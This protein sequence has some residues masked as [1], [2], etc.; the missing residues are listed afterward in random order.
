MPKF[1]AWLVPSLLISAAGCPDVS[2]DPGEGVDDTATAGPVVEFDPANKVLPFPNNLVLDPTTGKVNLPKQ[3]NE[4]A[5]STSTRENVLN[6]LDGF[7]TYE[8][9]MSVTFTE[10]V[11]EATLTDRVVLYKRA[12][13]MTAA[14]TTA[15]PVLLRKGTTIRYADQ[16]ML[17]TT[18]MCS[19]PKTIDSVTIIP[20]VP[21]DQKSTYTVAVLKGV[22]TATGA[23]YGSTFTWSLIRQAENPVTLDAQGNVVSDRTPLLPSDPAQY[24]QLKGIDLLWK[25]HA[26]AL[27]FLSAKHAREDVLI[28]WEFN[29]QTVTDPLDPTVAGSLAAMTK[30]QKLGLVQSVTGPFTAEQFL[31]SRLPPGSC[32]IDG[33]SLPCGAVGSVI[34]GLLAANSYQIQLP[35]KVTTNSPNPN[36]GGPIPG[37]FG[38]PVKPMK[39]GDVGIA[40][41]GMVPCVGAPPCPTAVEPPNGWPTIIYGHPLGSSKTTLAGIGS[42]LAAA[43]FASVAIDF[44]AHDSR[45]VRISTD[46]ALGCNTRLDPGPQPASCPTPDLDDPDCLRRPLPTLDGQCYSPFLSPD[47]ATTRDNIR[48]SILDLHELV[49]A[50]KACGTTECNMLKVDQTNISYLALSLGGLLGPTFVATKGGDL[51]SSVLASQGV[52]WVDILVNTQTNA[53]KCPLVDALIG[54]G[55]LTGDKWNPSVTPNTGLCTTE[56]WKTQPGFVQFSVIARWALDPADGANFT[57]MLATR[58]VLL[59]QVVGD[60]VIPNLAQNN[61]A[62]LIGLTPRA[63]DPA[64]AQPIQPSA[65][66]TEMPTMSKFVKYMNLPPAA[67]SFPG[68]TFEH[69]SLLR[70]APTP[71]GTTVGFDGR[72]G[73]A[74]MQIDA[75]TFLSLNKA[76]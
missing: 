12:A 61:E 66:I 39:V 11:D 62:A 15:V 14:N 34:G 40:V 51:R 19:D 22:K 50:L 21:L 64:A 54:A 29:T 20:L 63:A 16:T 69:P 4:S 23:D 70:P 58:K 1:L 48:Q 55:I 59:Q 8:V 27:Q 13:G 47:L 73:T 43:G 45:A 68:N 7:G 3:C 56:A 30:N 38:D 65:A 28:A 18:G 71:G 25:A 10:A 52:G 44:V 24:E 36:E 46:A 74:R 35:A 31:Q 33:G 26:Q 53:V 60:M 32:T 9:A 5:L 2:V 72:L 42:Q 75:I 76:N 67:P 57:K 6:K 17:A 37:A 41:F 49:G